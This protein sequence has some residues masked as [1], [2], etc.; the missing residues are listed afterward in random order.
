MSNNNKIKIKKISIYLLILLVIIFIVGLL[1]F[2]IKKSSDQGDK[3]ILNSENISQSDKNIKKNMS[4]NASTNADNNQFKD[5]LK[6]LS[7]S[8]D[9]KSAIPQEQLEK[10]IQSMNAK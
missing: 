4:G 6:N 5:A 7:A 8:P 10:V 1:V 9:A 2:K 3:K